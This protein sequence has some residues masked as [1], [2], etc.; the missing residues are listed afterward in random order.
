[1]TLDQS[2]EKPTRFSCEVNFAMFMSV[3]LRGWMP[4]LIA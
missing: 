4:V 1:M 2:K 3:T